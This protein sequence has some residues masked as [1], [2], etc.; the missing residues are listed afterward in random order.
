MSGRVL[1]TGGAK[2]VGAAIVRTLAVAGY[3][4]DFTYRSSAEQA[5]A[6]A[7]E[8]VAAH[9]GRA[10]RALPL[11]LADK[12]AVVAFCSSLEETTYY[13]YVHNA[14]QSYDV[15][16]AMLTQD[17]AE[18][19]MQVN[20]WSMT[21]IV[22][23]VI[24]P[25]MRARAGRIVGIGSVA[26]LEGN[27]GNSAYAATK[28]AMLSYIRTLAVESAKRGVTVNYVAPGFIDTDMPAPDANYRD[29]MEKQISRRAL[30]PAG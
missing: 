8:V 10:I 27:Q 5:Q 9:S 23:A 30:R 11:D 1:V 24:R 17:K 4:I 3:D 2:G 22:K 6:L 28:G 20:F 21:Q 25:M 26:A 16:A 13:G 29:Q 14:G 19:I 7:G 18:A 12:A 15:L